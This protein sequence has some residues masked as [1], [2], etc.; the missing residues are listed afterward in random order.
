MHAVAGYRGGRGTSACTQGATVGSGGALDSCTDRWT[1][2]DRLSDWVLLPEGETEDQLYAVLCAVGYNLKR[3]LS[4][5][6]IK[7]IGLW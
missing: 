7:Y 4:V 6:A 1:P 2:E 3:L 5:S